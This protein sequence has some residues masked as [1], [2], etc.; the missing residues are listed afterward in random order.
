MTVL[1]G[2]AK[3]L[4]IKVCNNEHSHW[5]NVSIFL[6]IFVNCGDENH[7]S[8]CMFQTIWEVE[9]VF[10]FL[11][12]LYFFLCQL[13]YLFPFLR[14]GSLT[15]SCDFKKLFIYYGSHMV[16]WKHFFSVCCLTFSFVYMHSLNRN[17]KNI[18]ENRCLNLSFMALK[19]WHVFGRP[20]SPPG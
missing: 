12:H 14:G 8:I 3:L 17:L 18:S 2:V 9:W 1:L 5:L 4:A 19:V 15:F 20:F 7:I 16:L 10:I 11:G 6:F 13:P